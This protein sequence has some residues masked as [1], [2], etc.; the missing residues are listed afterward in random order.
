MHGL[1]Y[2]ANA[3]KNARNELIAWHDYTSKKTCQSNF[4]TNKILGWPQ[5]RNSAHNDM[6]S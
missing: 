1:A 2:R 3:R 4:E 6:Q 5:I